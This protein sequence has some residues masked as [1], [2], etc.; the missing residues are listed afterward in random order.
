MKPVLNK[1]KLLWLRLQKGWSQEDAASHCGA[2]D[3]KQYHLWET[4][5]TL[6]P[7][8][9]QLDAI[10][11]GF[12]L[13]QSDEIL[14]RPGESPDPAL[15]IFY[16][17]HF[18]Q[19]LSLLQQEPLDEEQPYR[20]ICFS[21]DAV[22]LR[23]FHFSW[24]EVWNLLGDN[25]VQ[26]KK[27]L[28]LFHSGRMSYEDWCLWCCD[29]FRSHDLH[30]EQL[31]ALAQRYSVIDHLAEGLHRLRKAG[32]R[33]ALISGGLD[34]FLQTL[35]PDYMQWFDQVFINRM[36]FDEQG[37]IRTIVPTPFD[38]ERKP[39]AVRYLCSL[40]GLHAAQSICVGSNFVDSH[41][42]EAAGLTIA[43]NSSSDEIRELFDLLIDGGD[44]G[45]LVDVVLA[46]NIPEHST[47][48]EL[49]TTT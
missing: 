34:I 40:Y 1:E 5:K 13:D 41:Y 44:F 32:F 45:E 30:R 27:G 12:G 23:G 35:I 7:R 33:L 9:A 10:A 48:S 47:I 14:L 2:S 31:Q 3:K 18:R 42:I 22:L 16:Q 4:G 15:Q 46:L 8:A 28:K 21:L 11:A 25:S 26:R 24:E 49:A 17:A 39:D 29:I 6:L 20:L 43:L 38:L 19:P 37:R 36:E